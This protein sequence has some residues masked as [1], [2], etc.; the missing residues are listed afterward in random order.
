[1]NLLRRR[2]NIPPD[3]RKEIVVD[4]P[5]IKFM[6]SPSPREVL[7][8]ALDY[9]VIS[10]LPNQSSVERNCTASWSGMRWEISSKHIE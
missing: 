4:V 10:L 3:T 7:L 6:H 5:E 9:A 8:T 2:Q 1:M